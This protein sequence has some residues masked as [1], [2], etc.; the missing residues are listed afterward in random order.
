MDMIFWICVKIMQVNKY[1]EDKGIFEYD[2]RKA[3]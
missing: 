2:D 1:T 3:I